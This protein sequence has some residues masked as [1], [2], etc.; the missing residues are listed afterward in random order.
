MSRESDKMI[1]DALKTGI[2]GDNILRPLS[3]FT[4]TKQDF[5]PQA[6]WEQYVAS[7]IQA[8]INAGIKK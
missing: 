8:K 2:R 1:R 4:V 5:T 7:L 3:D 6:R